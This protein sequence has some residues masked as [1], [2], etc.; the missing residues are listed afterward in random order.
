MLFVLTQT[1]GID[2]YHLFKILY[3]AD[4]KHLSKWGTKILPDD[5]HALNYGPVPTLLYD[6][7]KNNAN[8]IKLQSVFNESVKFAGDDAPN[9]MLAKKKVDMDYLSKSEVEALDESI[10]ENVNLTFAELKVK[11]HDMA[12]ENAFTRGNH[13]MSLLDMAEVANADSDTLAYVKDQLELEEA[14]S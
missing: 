11:S 3:F 1:K 4:L 8:N 13:K 2:Y 9:V 12:W 14:L 6:L 5:F 7:V 10:K